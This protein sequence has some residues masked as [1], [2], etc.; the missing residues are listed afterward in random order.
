MLAT[1]LF[2]VSIDGACS[3]DIESVSN[4]ISPSIGGA[5]S[6]AF[7]DFFNEVTTST[8]F[9]ETNDFLFGKSNAQLLREAGELVG[10]NSDTCAECEAEQSSGN[11]AHGSV[12]DVGNG[13]DGCDESC[14]G[15]AN[16]S[17]AEYIAGDPIDYRGMIES[18]HGAVEA[19]SAID[20]AEALAD[21]DDCVD[22]LYTSIESTEFGVGQSALSKTSQ[23]MAFEHLQVCI[24]RLEDIK[25]EIQ[26]VKRLLLP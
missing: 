7:T 20:H 26:R 10:D 12:G 23:D 19:A 1:K 6:G 15:W 25:V 8:A 14:P 4:S 22:E 11:V 17:F 3:V 21:V 2:F 9:P 18:S 24:N 16:E 13:P 5:M